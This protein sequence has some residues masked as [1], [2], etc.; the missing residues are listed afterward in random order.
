MTA[1]QCVWLNRAQPRV[2]KGR[3]RQVE[4][5]G[6]ARQV[7]CCK[8]SSVYITGA[9]QVELFGRARQVDCCTSSSM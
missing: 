3:D 1:R 6:R 7:D 2:L 9:R 4:L 5:I 8:S